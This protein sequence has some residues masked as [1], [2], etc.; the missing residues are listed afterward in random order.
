M[1]RPA[2]PP[3]RRTVLSP[4]RAEGY[5]TALAISRLLLGQQ[6]TAEVGDG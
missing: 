3:E 1:K 4:W 2:Q 5:D 6:R